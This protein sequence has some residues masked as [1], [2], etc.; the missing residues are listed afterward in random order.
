MAAEISNYK[1]LPAY[2][3]FNLSY[4]GIEYAWQDDP[5][6]ITY[7]DPKTSNEFSYAIVIIPFKKE[8]EKYRLV[9]IIEVDSKPQTIPNISLRKLIE[10][11]KWSCVGMYYG[12]NGVGDAFEKDSEYISAFNKTDRSFIISNL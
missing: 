7:I 4:K 11:S 2:K 8:I 1:R 3:K 9:K 6:T 10:E 5:R 12:S